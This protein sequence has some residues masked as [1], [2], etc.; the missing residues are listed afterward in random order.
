MNKPLIS[1]LYQQVYDQIL[2]EIT[3][4]KWR[5]NEKLPTE[6]E[7][8]KQLNVSQGTVRKAFDNLVSQRIVIR[9]QGKGTFLNKHKPEEDL[10]LFFRFVTKEN[11]KIYPTSKVIKQSIKPIPKPIAN[12]LNIEDKDATALCVERLR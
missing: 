10:F 8:A 3:T 12:K 6:Y 11:K 7:F 5:I 2:K 9:Q 4:Q 1:P